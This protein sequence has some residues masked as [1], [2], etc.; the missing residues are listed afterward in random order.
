[1]LDRSASTSQNRCDTKVRTVVT[2]R[3]Q[4]SFTIANEM[5]VRNVGDPCGTDVIVAALSPR[6]PPRPSYPLFGP[7]IEVTAVA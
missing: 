6:L 1:M 3:M 4:K 5:E 7:S 2:I